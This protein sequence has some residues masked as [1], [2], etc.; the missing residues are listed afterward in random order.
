MSGHTC[1][2]Q[3]GWLLHCLE[4][5]Q[6]ILPSVK[7][8]AH[9]LTKLACGGK[10]SP[11]LKR[12]VFPERAQVGVCR[13]NLWKRSTIEDTTSQGKLPEAPPDARFMSWAAAVH[14]Y[15]RL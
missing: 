5:S 4:L 13:V 14:V 12:R 1:Q 10:R 6:H 15:G 3:W 9:S 11:L 2:L 7:A 8:A